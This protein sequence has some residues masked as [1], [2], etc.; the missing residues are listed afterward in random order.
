MRKMHCSQN[1]EF[2][3]HKINLNDFNPALYKIIEGKYHLSRAMQ[4][5]VSGYMRTARPR[6]ACASAQSDQGFCCPQTES[7]D[8][9]ECLSGEQILR[10]RLYACTG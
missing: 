4:K 7:L 1:Y 10:M 8:T 3:S 5:H 2:I 6:P 9:I